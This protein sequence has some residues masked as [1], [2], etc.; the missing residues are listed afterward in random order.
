MSPT[1]FIDLY[2]ERTDPSF[3]SEPLNA[4]TNASFLIGAWYAWRAVS[5]MKSIPPWTLRVLPVLLAAV[6]ICSFLFHTLATVW[7]VVADQLTILLFGCVFLYAFLHHAARF[8]R[9]P[10][11][12]V[13]V[14]F[15]VASYYFPR[16]LPPGLLNQSGAYLP[17]LLGL[18]AMTA[19]LTIRRRAAAK[20]FAGAIALFCLALLFRTVDQ[21]WCVQFPLGTHFLWHLLNGIVLGLLSI[22]LLHEVPRSR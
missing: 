8:P 11:L 18:L 7:A 2:C 12:T 3:W 1:Q 20:Q 6:G 9:I 19:W 10:A 21:Y 13:A 4:L 22:A 17:Y 15:G 14:L 5:G 16:L